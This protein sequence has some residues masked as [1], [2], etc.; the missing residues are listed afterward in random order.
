[1]KMKM[2]KRNGSCSG[3]KD[4]SRFCSLPLFWLPVLLLSLWLVVLWLCFPS[5]SECS[6][7][8]FKLDPRLDGGARARRRQR[9]RRDFEGFCAL[10]LFQ[11]GS[12]TN[13]LQENVLNVHEWLAKSNKSPI[14]LELCF[15]AP[16]LACASLLFLKTV[17]SSEHRRIRIR[18]GSVADQVSSLPFQSA[19]L[20]GTSSVFSDVQWRNYF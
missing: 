11:C 9:R 19:F 1:M 18:S 13:V 10:W 2:R 15:V 20:W 6:A 4:C 16:T 7:D 8:S 14:K 5:V 17:R 12:D 3:G